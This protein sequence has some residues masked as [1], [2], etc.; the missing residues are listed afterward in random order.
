LSDLAHTTRRAAIVLLLGILV[1]GCGWRLQGALAFPPELQTVR[2]A[3]GEEATRER[4]GVALSRAGLRTSGDDAAD[5]LLMIHEDIAGERMVSVTAGGRPNEFEVYRVIEFS[6]ARAGAMVLDHRRIE[7]TADY[8]YST[9]AV[10]AGQEESRQ[11]A[12]SLD[13][14]LRQQLLRELEQAVAR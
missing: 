11:L 4:L 2:V 13:G 14:R 1:A 9:T 6:L 12:E 10:L 8:T 3:G 7:L 5:L